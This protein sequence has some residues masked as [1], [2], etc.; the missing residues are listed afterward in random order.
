MAIDTKL[1]SAAAAALKGGERPAPD[2]VKA[3]AWTMVSVLAFTL[4]AW[5]GREAG[6]HMTPM[7]M[8]FWRNLI[9]LLI[10][11]AAFRWLDISLASLKPSRP[12]LQWGRALLH[13]CGQWS[14]MTALLLIPL[15]EL[16]ALEFTFPLWVALLAPLLLGEKLTQPRVLAAAMGFAGVLVIILG[17]T[18]VSGGKVGPSFNKG[19]LM[20]LACAVFFCFNIIGSRYLLRFDGPLTLLMFMVVNHTVLAFVLGFPTL[21]LP[22]GNLVWWVMLLGI[23]SLIAHF[24]LA[25]A[26]AYADSTIVATLDFMRIPLMVL[27]GAIAYHEPLHAITLIGA[28][29]V[30][31]GNGVNI[32]AEHKRRASG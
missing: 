20:A 6:K 32:W 21:R 16:M 1:K 15:I 2:L 18:L 27:L 12:W 9:S 30:L 31:T 8:V 28:A 14:W 19:T 25:R 29:L 23:S 22:R 11:L 5:S 17:P 3:V 4:T 10:L 7:N 24:A 13:F 26:L